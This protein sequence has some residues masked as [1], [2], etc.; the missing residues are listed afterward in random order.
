[1]KGS[2][3]QKKSNKKYYPIIYLGKDELTG[4]KIRKWGT[5]HE[6][7]KDAEAELR[8]LL[9]SYDNDDIETGKVTFQYAYDLWI[10]TVA[11]EQYDS[12]KSLDTARGHAKNHIL[13]I[14][15]S[16]KL[17]DI[18]PA[19]LQKFFVELST[20]KTKK[21]KKDERKPLAPQTKK[22]ILS[23]MRSVFNL[24][25][26]Y[27]FL[28]KSP[29]DKI[30]IGKGISFE[31]TPWT[32]DQLQYFLEL[33]EVKESP[34]YITIIIA[35]TCGMRRGEICGLQWK[36]YNGHSL[37]LQRGM[38]DKG[39]L[40]NMKNNS[41]HR[42]IELMDE[43]IFALEGQKE[44]QR[45]SKE[46]YKKDYLSSDFIC[47]YPDGKNIRPCP[48]TE[49]FTKLIKQNNDL[50]DSDEEI[51][52]G[53]MKLPAIRFHDLRHTFATIALE[54]NID[55]K[56]VSEI[57]GHSDT[58]TTQMIYQNV[59]SELQRKA[60]TKIGNNI[61]GIEKGIESKNKSQM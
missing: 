16:K 48:V 17:S 32:R 9:S 26:E 52:K 38:S 12:E 31:Y 15:G 28:N 57:L 5:G 53:R 4:K 29:A 18:E 50:A 24:A 20:E 39:K 11:P 54:N 40:T 42:R 8:K 14:W 30:L 59:S 27:N 41:S 55:T 19:S 44:Y 46:I 1:M 21:L 45:L 36:D 37:H 7:E 3:F 6:K 2:V 22:K 35:L 61:F 25:I 58:R 33:K 43:T 56:I 60:I 47:T 49:N 10:D 13:P 34:Y 23:I 51:N